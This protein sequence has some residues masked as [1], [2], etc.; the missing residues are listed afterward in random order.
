[1]HC[2]KF[3]YIQQNETILLI[4]ATIVKAENIIIT[5]TS[6]LP[7]AKLGKFCWDLFVIKGLILGPLEFW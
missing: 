2:T 1:M 5:R 3:M 6:I 7:W 4:I